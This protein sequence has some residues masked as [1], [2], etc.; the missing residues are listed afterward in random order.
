MKKILCICLCSC[1]LFLC[2]CKKIIKEDSPETSRLFTS[3]LE[4][5]CGDGVFVSCNI[6]RLGAESWR[7]EMSSPDEIEGIVLLYS[8]DGITAEYHGMTFT[9]AKENTP[10]KNILGSVFKCIDHSSALVAMPYEETENGRIFFG[11]CDK[12]KYT[13]TTDN[14]DNI[15]AVCLEDMGL[16]ATLEDFCVIE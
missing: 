8:P 14:D 16:S 3:A 1:M 4:I 2:G 9:T 5:D 15:T 12:G 7:A 6:T 10:E 13:I 11:E